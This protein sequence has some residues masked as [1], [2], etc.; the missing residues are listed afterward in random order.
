MRVTS[1]DLDVN[2]FRVNYKEFFFVLFLYFLVLELGSKSRKLTG[3]V[4]RK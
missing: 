2:L 4:G 1:V 3:K